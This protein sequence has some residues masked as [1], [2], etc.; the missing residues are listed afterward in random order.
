MSADGLDDPI[1]IQS[2]ARHNTRATQQ[3]N[4]AGCCRFGTNNAT[5]LNNTV[6]G[7]QGPNG[8]GNIVR[9]MGKGHGAGSKHHHHGKY[10]F[11]IHQI[12]L[13]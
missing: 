9:A 3:Q 1:A 12:Q 5:A 11:H 7:G 4:P 10:F 2:Q 8:I 13:A 6:D